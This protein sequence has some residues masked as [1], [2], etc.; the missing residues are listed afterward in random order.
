MRIGLI[1]VDGHNFPNLA[2]MRISAYHKARGD[3]VEWWKGDMFHYDKVY[4]SKVFSD[5][6]SRNIPDPM[7]AD[8]V[9][10][11]GT[12]YAIRLQDGKEVFDKSK[13]VVLPDEIEK[14]FPDYSI[15]PEYPFAVSMTSR[16][17]PRGCAFCHVAA[18]EGRASIKVADVSS[19][20]G[21]AKRN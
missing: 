8:E 17:C 21:G 3:K 5:A 10:K 16:G 15:Y 4:M 6:Y 14:M 9:I 18:K 19:F 12:G 7:N 13:D 1:D 2:L 11:G 20:W